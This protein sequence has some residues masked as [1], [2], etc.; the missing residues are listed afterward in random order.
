MIRE[1]RWGRQLLFAGPSRYGG[2]RPIGWP[3]GGGGRDRW[4]RSDDWMHGLKGAD[5]EL[6]RAQLWRHWASTQ[7][8]HDGLE[9][10]PLQHHCRA[11]QWDGAVGA[12]LV[13]WVPCLQ[14]RDYDGVLPNCRDVNSRNWEVE[15]LCQEGQSVLTKMAVEES[16]FLM[17]TTTPLLSK[18]RAENSINYL[19]KACAITTVFNMYHRL[20]GMHISSIKSIIIHQ[21]NPSNELHKNWQKRIFS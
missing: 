6:L 4:W 9:E 21:C 3:W 11:E 10:E 2:K 18:R 15:E 16:G 7:C 12:A 17:A 13:S 20:S 1:G 5:I 14:N 19:L 8:L